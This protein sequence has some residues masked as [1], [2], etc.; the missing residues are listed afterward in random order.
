MGFICLCL[1]LIISQPQT[2]AAQQN[3]AAYDLWLI[4]SQAIT[5][6]LM[7]DASD[8][9]PSARPILWARLAQRWWH[10]DPPKARSWILKS[11]ESVESVPN[12]ENPDERLQRLNTVRLLL[13]I[14]GPLDQ[15]LSARLITLF[16]Q[17]SEHGSDSERKATADGLVEAALSIVDTNPQRAAELGA[18]ALRVG[19]PP[20]ISSLLILLRS[21][22][23][24]LADTLFTQALASARQSLDPELI[25]SLAHVAFPEAAWLGGSS[26]PPFPDGLR[27]EMLRI[28]LAYLQVNP[29]NSESR[30]NVCLFVISLVA[31]V[32]PQFDRLLPQQAAAARQTISQCQ[33]ISPVAQQHLDDAT[34]DVP[35]N[36]VDDLLKAADDAKDE[37]V[38]TIYLYKAASLAR[39]RNDF[40]RALSILDSMS[41]ESREFMGGAWESYRWDWAASSALSHLK[42]GDVY[43]MRL[44]INAVPAP[45]QPFALIAFLDRLPA[46]R[47]KDTDPTLEFLTDARIGLSRSSVP[48]TEK[49]YWYFG[50]LRLVVQYQPIEATAV[51]NDAVAALN[52]AEGAKEKD[53]SNNRDEALSEPQFVKTLPALLFEMDEFVVK[54]AVASIASPTIRAQIRLELLRVSLERLNGS[55]QVNPKPKRS[56]KE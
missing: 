45:L 10:V 46:N 50:L 55:K 26:N 35:L 38:R 42:N 9:S 15:K 21:K 40:D 54:G 41:S 48:D 47:N 7:K 4:R 3:S 43:G 44:I 56:T 53:T 19:R 16:T 14:V 17:T 6:Y 1:L 24:K 36:T 5:A 12:R 37:K 29:I 23:A 22:D 31:P 52:R 13:K 49:S 11:I 28:Q 51:L 27:T 18:L 30:N 8:L 33:A 32:L 25:N 34:R 39:Q 2:R 20:L